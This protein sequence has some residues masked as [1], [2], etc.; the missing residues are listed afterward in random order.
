MERHWKIVDISSRIKDRKK[1][2][3]I[4][5]IVRRDFQNILTL[6]SPIRNSQRW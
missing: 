2:L 5:K 1:L 3:N 4:L 6:M